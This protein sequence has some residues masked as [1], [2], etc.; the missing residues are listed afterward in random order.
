MAVP[1]SFATPRLLVAFIY[2]PVRI[3]LQTPISHMDYW[4]SACSLVAHSTTIS[5]DM[6]DMYEQRGGYG[7]ARLW[8]QTLA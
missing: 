5:I 8:V 2:P 4:N 6:T 1:G 3:L 7:T